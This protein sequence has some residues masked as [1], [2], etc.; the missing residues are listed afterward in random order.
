MEMAKSSAMGNTAQQKWKEAGFEVM[1]SRFWKRGRTTV[2]LCFKLS[3]TAILPD[4]HERVIAKLARSQRLIAFGKD[5]NRVDGRQYHLLRKDELEE[6]RKDL[7]LAHQE[8]LHTV[9]YLK[10]DAPTANVEAM[11]KN[12]LVELDLALSEAS[13]GRVQNAGEHFKRILHTIRDG[14]SLLRI[15]YPKHQP[16][17]LRLLKD[18]EGIW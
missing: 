13:V 10:Q 3:E 7:H 1:E 18:F 12:I 15:V 5:L 2:A 11:M 9:G 16:T 8:I 17:F 14:G 6:M 4:E